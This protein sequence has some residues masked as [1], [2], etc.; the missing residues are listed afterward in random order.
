MAQANGSGSFLRLLRYVLLVTL[1]VRVVLPVYVGLVTGDT[2]AFFEVYTHEYREP[3]RN[4]LSSGSYTA[5]GKPEIYRPPGYPLFLLPGLLLKHE[6]IV[7]IVLQMILSLLTVWLVFR[8]SL[9]IFENVA[10]ALLATLCY[11]LEPLSIVFCSLL[12]PETLMTCLL[13]AF[14]LYFCKYVK[15]GAANDLAVCAVLLG[16][17]SYVAAYLCFLPLLMVITLCVWGFCD[18]RPVKPSALAEEGR[19]RGTRQ[20]GADPSFSAC[21]PLRHITVF[22]FIC[23]VLL[24]A[25]QVRN[26]ATTGYWGFSGIFDR[27]MYYAQ[28]ASLLAEQEGKPEFQSAWDELDG[29]LAAQVG[30]DANLSDELRY[31]RSA[32]LKAVLRAPL[33]YLQI[34]VKGMVKTLAGLE[35]HT[36]LRLLNPMPG[37]PEGWD[38]LI[39]GKGLMRSLIED[40]SGASI[41]VFVVIALLAGVLA[42]LYVFSAFAFISRT[43]PWTMPV[44]MLMTVAAYILVITGGPHGYSRY[45]HGIM[46][47]ICIFA[48]YG[49]AMLW[50][51]YGSRPSQQNAGS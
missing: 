6:A 26:Y 29:R 20:L 35:A 3:A 51:R 11:A 4:L 19:V 27:S 31:M 44:L 8:L 18:K 38:S 28:A 7:T 48:G 46:P 37:Q 15:G 45:R 43:I 41:A 21:S 36:F 40:R 30:R 42:A 49:L 2:V 47:I 10:A 5:S 16:F 25:W 1:L 23:A 13:T 50:R 14:L 12:M 9:L 34:H 33:Q 32:G 39:H 24:G 22:L 17:S